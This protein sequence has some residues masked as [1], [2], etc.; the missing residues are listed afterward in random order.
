MS[1]TTSWLS[2]FILSS[3]KWDATIVTIATVILV[4]TITLTLRI[5]Y[6]YQQQ[7]AQ[8]LLKKHIGSSLYP[9]SV[10]VQSTRYYIEP[11]CS[12]I[13][14]AR[15]NEIRNVRAPKEGIF[16]ALDNFIAQ[17]SVYRHIIVLA[18]SGMGKTSV[19]IN[20]FVRNYKRRNPH[21]I[22]LLP[23]GIPDLKDRI[24]AI[25]DQK[26]TTI[27]LDAFDED[28]KA[29]IEHKKRL[30]ELMELCLHF[31]R[32]AISCR[33]QFFLDDEEIPNETG[34]LRVGPRSGGEGSVYKFQKL[35]LMPLT[36]RQVA[37]YL[38]KRYPFWEWRQRRKAQ[39]LV[40]KIPL[41]SVRPMVLTHIPDL[42]RD[43]ATIEH[44]FQLYEAII[45]A[46]LQR[47]SVWLDP[48]NLRRFSE[49]L[50][51]EIFVNRE[52]RGSEL[53]TRDELLTLVEAWN[54]PLND[55]LLSWRSLLNRDADGNLKFAHRSIMEYLFIQCDVSQIKQIWTE[56]FLTNQM[57]HFVNDIVG[58]RN[59]SYLRNIPNVQLSHVDLSD[60]E[61]TNIN[62]S[63][64]SLIGANLTNAN[65]KN[66]NLN[67]ANLKGATLTNVNLSL[68][69]YDQETIWPTQFDFRHS[70]AIGPKADLSRIDLSGIDLS[71]TDLSQATLQN[72]DLRNSNL[73]YTD[74]DK[75]NLSGAN[76]SGA[77]LK[78]AKLDRANLSMATY[79]ATT[80]WPA[81]FD[82]GETGSE[83]VQNEYTPIEA[84][85]LSRAQ[86]HQ[87]NIALLDA[88]RDSSDLSRMVRIGLDTNL[89]TIVNTDKSFS[90]IVF[91]LINWAESQGNLA[92]LIEAALKFNEGNN[93]LRI[94]AQSVDF[95]FNESNEIQ[96]LQELLEQHQRN[97]QLLIRQKA[98][99]GSGEE[100]L[101]LVNQI[102][103]EEERIQNI[104]ERL[105]GGDSLPQ[106]YTSLNNSI[107]EW[108]RVAETQRDCQS[109]HFIA[110]ELESFVTSVY[111]HLD[112]IIIP[113]SSYLHRETLVVFRVR[114]P[115]IHLNLPREFLTIWIINDEV[116]DEIIEQFQDI[117]SILDIHTDFGLV[118]A[119]TARRQ[120]QKLVNSV[121][122]PTMKTDLIVLG[123]EFLESFAISSD[124]KTGLLTEILRE[125]ELTRISPF[126]AGGIDLVD[127]M[128]FGREGE[129]KNI[130]EAI[131]KTSVVISCGRRMGKT[132]LLNRMFRTVLPARNSPCFF[133]NCQPVHDYHELLA[134]MS[135]A[136]DL[137]KLPFDPNS[138]NS[139]EAVVQ[140]LTSLYDSR[141]IFLFDEVDGLVSFDSQNNWQLFKQLRALSLDGRARFIM[142]GER[143][144][145][146]QLHNADSPLFNFFGL[147][148]LLT[149]LS[150]P[151][152]RDLV[153]KPMNDM[154]IEIEEPILTLNKILNY[155]SGHPYLLQRLCQ[156]LIQALNIQGPRT[157]QNSHIEFVLNDSSYQEDYF[158]TIWG[159]SPT[160]A[161]IITLLIDEQGA[162]LRQIRS[163]LNEYKLYPKL[164]DIDDALKV[165]E[166]YSVLVRKKGIFLFAATAFP[167]MVRRSYG[168]DI[169]IN[170]ELL[171][172]EYLEQA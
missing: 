143:T 136:W 124:K 102:S 51:V 91:S 14:P 166:L 126:M 12:I 81:H 80:R 40:E 56:T 16:D 125:V 39:R 32:V 73:F 151:A 115:T 15:E 9:V 5:W 67:G 8:R 113:D 96:F 89:D 70:G 13:D 11:D 36:D 37:K 6:F 90:S 3:A 112:F 58:S 88:Y 160:L 139:F 119:P 77:N 42:L 68:A 131:E 123:Q 7:L 87:F 154:Q 161:Q 169:D 18:D 4:V 122:R 69:K 135:T 108:K 26:N 95:D 17:D 63:N 31:E 35:Y 142:T 61:L 45:D 116:T 157:V 170:I 76:L 128:F 24:E 148:I 120:I 75:A 28:F 156:G 38:R 140:D 147:N 2:Q 133:L 132:T 98:A 92:K 129:L 117:P 27:F 1:E 104:L 144:L 107:N 152:A 145:Q 121:I 34:I 46:W 78:G 109:K 83:L 159:Q 21:K 48:K 162:T 59:F 23:I 44:S 149:F 25:T 33:T 168:E 101:R 93:S 49:L 82:P 52:K 66:G 60:A 171:C 71:G 55:M 43:G 163:R 155:T 111:R 10:L 22:V 164:G 141:P 127:R 64:A 54:I 153:Q 105:A 94:F 130:V 47:E 118:F 86:I 74:L 114:T 62:L 103:A 100:P 29:I 65:L 110:P 158:E 41:L 85:S 53:I 134:E 167:N 138:P 50:A 84:K 79:D 146:N 97:L 150:T 99:Y 72:A 172:E 57:E 106:Q 30:R 20:Y 137:P 19:F 165:L